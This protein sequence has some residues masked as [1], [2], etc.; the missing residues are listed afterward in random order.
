[1]RTRRFTTAFAEALRREP[2]TDPQLGR[3][4]VAVAAGGQ[5]LDQAAPGCG[6]RGPGRVV[7]V[8][9]PA[10]G[11]APDPFD[12]T[13][14]SR[15][16]RAVLA[17]PARRGP[18]GVAQG[19]QGPPQHQHVSASTNGAS[20]AR[21][22]PTAPTPRRSP[23]SCRGRCLRSPAAT[24]PSGTSTRSW[25]PRA[26]DPDSARRGRQRSASSCAAVPRCW[27]RS[28]PPRAL[29]RRAP[30][31]Q[32][33]RG[34]PLRLPGHADPGRR[35]S[36]GRGR[37][38][39]RLAEHPARALPLRAHRRV[40]GHRRGAVGDLPQASSSTATDGHV[41]DRDRRSQAGHL[42]LSAAPTST[43]TCGARERHRG[44]RR[45]RASF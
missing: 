11:A 23:G 29:G 24:T 4:A 13:P 12:P 33:A 26:T 3:A 39:A 14:S 38:P 22:P 16:Q 8:P 20:C 2:A 34:G 43:P 6:R 42:L 19:G 1:M 40:P 31:G 25:T 35:G 7:S 30:R 5:R 41:L 9:A 17:A 37:P 10:R 36:A 32:Q 45:A 15:P 44:G 27:P 21:W 28:S 18:Q